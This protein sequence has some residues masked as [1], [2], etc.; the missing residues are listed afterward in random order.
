MISAAPD[1]QKQETHRNA[2]REKDTSPAPSSPLEDLATAYRSLFFDLPLAEARLWL[3]IGSE[4]EVLDAVWAE[5]DALSHLALHT[6]GQ[7]ERWPS[8]P[9]RIGKG[10][11]TQTPGEQGN[12]PPRKT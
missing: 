7:G 1:L 4:H 12:K 8:A 9:A 10:C 5:Y 11:D 2:M 6:L 3:G